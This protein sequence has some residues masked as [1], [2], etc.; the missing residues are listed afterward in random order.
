MAATKFMDHWHLLARDGQA[1][2]MLDWLSK[3]EQPL[4]ESAPAGLQWIGLYGTV[5]WRRGLGMAPLHR[6]GQL[7][8]H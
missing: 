4:A 6:P 8:S 1:D 5:F 7:R 2:K 3:S